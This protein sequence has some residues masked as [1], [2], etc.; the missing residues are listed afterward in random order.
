MYVRFCSV[1][2]FIIAASQHA[3]A[4]AISADLH[5]PPAGLPSVSDIVGHASKSSPGGSCVC[6]LAWT[7]FRVLRTGY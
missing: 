6:V 4:H 2:W 1:A 3:V 5:P 7:V